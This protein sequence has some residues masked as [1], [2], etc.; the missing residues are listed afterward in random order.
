MACSGWAK[1]LITDF[2]EYPIKA[3]SSSKGE[4]IAIP[5]LRPGLKLNGRYLTEVTL[6]GNKQVIRW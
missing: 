1:S 3:I 2:S 6:T 4:L 5:K